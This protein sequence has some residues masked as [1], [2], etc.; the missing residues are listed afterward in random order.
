MLIV[1][2]TVAQLPSLDGLALRYEGD[3][4]LE[5]EAD[6]YNPIPG[7]RASL[8]YEQG[9]LDGFAVNVLHNSANRTM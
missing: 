2:P 6:A 1:M 8:A 4:A 3:V 9:V 5:Y 7:M